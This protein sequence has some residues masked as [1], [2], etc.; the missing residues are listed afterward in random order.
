MAGPSR[1][2]HSNDSIH[3]PEA[4]AVQ[5]IQRQG[6][7]QLALRNVS[8]AQVYYQTI[9]S[10]SSHVHAAESDSHVDAL[11]GVDEGMTE[12]MMSPGK[13]HAELTSNDGTSHEHESYVL[14]DHQHSVSE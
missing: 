2:S 12:K 4:R 10:G 14:E 5:P 11:V 1:N 3:F 8:P 13:V 9:E 6:G 7:N